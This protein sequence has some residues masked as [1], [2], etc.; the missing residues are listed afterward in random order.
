M[1]ETG[2]RRNRLA[3]LQLGHLLGDGAPGLR[4]EH[5]LHGAPRLPIPVIP[6]IA[7]RV[8]HALTAIVAL[9]L[10]AMQIFLP[11]Q[12]GQRLV[13]A[14]QAHI[15]TAV[16]FHAVAP[17]IASRRFQSHQRLF[18]GGVAAVGQQEELLA[19]QG[20]V[21]AARHLFVLFRLHDGGAAQPD[22][23]QQCGQAGDSE[24]GGVRGHHGARNPRR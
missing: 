11:L 17:V 18:V 14:I 9:D 2:R 12:K 21:V 5:A 3:H 19:F 22:G 24:G 16:G 4:V 7:E 8:R 20:T 13:D 10:D 15:G 23:Q 1:T 6:Q